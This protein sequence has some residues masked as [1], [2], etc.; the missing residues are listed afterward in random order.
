MMRRITIDRSLLV[1][2]KGMH[3]QVASLHSSGYQDIG[4]ETADK[5]V[6]NLQMSS[7]VKMKTGNLKS[8]IKKK[9]QQQGKIN[10]KLQNDRKLSKY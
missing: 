9:A 2:P 7:D 6:T 8:K 3:Q 4:N 1:V 5:S 10:G